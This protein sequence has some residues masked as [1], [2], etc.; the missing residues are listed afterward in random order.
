MIFKL[1]KKVL[2]WGKKKE[3][4][5]K[6]KKQKQRKKR[7]RRFVRRLIGFT[8]LLCL[9]AGGVFVVYTQR[10]QIKAMILDKVLPDG[11]LKEKLMAKV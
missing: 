1:V 4:K 6:K 9:A 2:H 10:S 7:V 3:K 8:L 11:K 5:E